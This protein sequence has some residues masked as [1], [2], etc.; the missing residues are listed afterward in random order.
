MR[1]HAGG[2]KINA[3]RRTSSD[4]VDSWPFDDRTVSVDSGAPAAQQRIDVELEHLGGVQPQ[5]FCPALFLQTAHLALDR[6]RRVRPRTFVM[7]I[8]IRPEKIA[9]KVMLFG[10]FE[11]DRIVLK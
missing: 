11:P 3:I 2:K 6:F 4:G 9:D 5:D 10:E 7:R 1:V 8:V